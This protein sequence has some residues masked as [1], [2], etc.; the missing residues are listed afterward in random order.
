MKFY[1]Y[2][3]IRIRKKHTLVDDDDIQ[4][5]TK[6]FDKNVLCT[7]SGTSLVYSF[8]FV[9]FSFSLVL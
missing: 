2:S 5:V 1:S 7:F 4:I 3:F 9:L 8:S 6:D